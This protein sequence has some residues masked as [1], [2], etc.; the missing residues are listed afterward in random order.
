MIKSSPNHRKYQEVKEAPT[1][2]C[3]EVELIIRSCCEDCQLH[4]ATESDIL[5]VQSS[6]GRI[7]TCPRLFCRSCGWLCRHWSLRRSSTMALNFRKVN[8]LWAN[9][10]NVSSWTRSQS[11]K[12]LA[13]YRNPVNSAWEGCSTFYP[14][15]VSETREIKYEVVEIKA[16]WVSEGSAEGVLCCTERELD[17]SVLFHLIHWREAVLNKDRRADGGW[18]QGKLPCICH[19]NDMKHSL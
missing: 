5:V 10:E 11:E 13:H 19:F 1:A 14:W 16:Y 8:P 17:K 12:W 6:T 15:V 4:C 3:S 2:F 9:D 18:R 7:P